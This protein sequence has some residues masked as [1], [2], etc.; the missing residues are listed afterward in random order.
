MGER[1]GT[2]AIALNRNSMQG[3]IGTENYRNGT[4]M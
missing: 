1:Y 4:I 3:W 2:E